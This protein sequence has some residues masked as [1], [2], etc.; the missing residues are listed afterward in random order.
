[1]KLSKKCLDWSYHLWADTL[2]IC[3]VEL[4]VQ[5]SPNLRCRS[6]TRSH[7]CVWPAWY[8]LSLQLAFISTVHPCKDIAL[9]ARSLIL[10][11]MIVIGIKKWRM[12]SSAKRISSLALKCPQLQSFPSRSKSLILAAQDLNGLL[13]MSTTRLRVRLRSMQVWGGRHDWRSSSHQDV[14]STQSYSMTDTITKLST[15]SHQSH[16]SSKSCLPNP[17]P[18]PFPGFASQTSLLSHICTFSHHHRRTN[19][20]LSRR[21]YPLYPSNSHAH[22]RMWKH[23]WLRCEQRRAISWT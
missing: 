4:E 8:R 19:W 6:P 11:Y 12:T 2:T 23:V 9:R 1:M 17:F 18:H 22:F 3:L 7:S 15:T 13:D 20:P 14:V 5:Y 21:R 10:N 16:Q